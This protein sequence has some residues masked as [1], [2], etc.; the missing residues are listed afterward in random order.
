MRIH[1]SPREHNI[2]LRRWHAD[3]RDHALSGPLMDT[4]Y[5]GIGVVPMG[6]MTL[7]DRLQTLSCDCLKGPNLFRKNTPFGKVQHCRCCKYTSH[8]NR[9]K[10]KRMRLEGKEVCR[11]EVLQEEDYA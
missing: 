2:M 10:I 9:M 6:A 8:E 7:E 3:K 11:G 1:T 4:N 5:T